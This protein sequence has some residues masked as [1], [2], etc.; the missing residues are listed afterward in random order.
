MCSSLSAFCCPRAPPRRIF[1]HP[2]ADGILASVFYPPRN[3][4]HDLVYESF[5]VYPTLVQMNTM[6]AKLNSTSILRTGDET[7]DFLIAFCILVFVIGGASN[8]LSTRIDGQGSYITGFS[9]V[10][11]A[12]L[13]YHQ[14][15]TVV[16]ASVLVRLFGCDMT[17]GRLY[18]TGIGGI[19]FTYPNSWF[20]RMMAWLIAGLAG[21]F[22]A[23][24]HLENMAV[25]GD[26]LKF[27]GVT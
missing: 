24:Y 21:S 12:A 25:W 5:C 19:V 23:K 1:A 4:L 8:L 13:A 14:R 7:V 9:P 27:F 20:P 3:L 16:R 2:I 15:I 6:I 10:I 17:A 11:A 26:M 18:L 22:L